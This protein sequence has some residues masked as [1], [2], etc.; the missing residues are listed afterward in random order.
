[1]ARLSSGTILFYTIQEYNRVVFHCLYME[2]LKKDYFYLPFHI[3][4]V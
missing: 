3:A 2:D 1:M 4:A